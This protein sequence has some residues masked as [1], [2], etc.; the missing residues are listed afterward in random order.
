MAIKTYRVGKVLIEGS[1]IGNVDNAQLAIDFA[2]A[3]TQAIGTD[4]R[5]VTP[6][7]RGASL[8]LTCSYDPADVP[9]AAI[10]TEFISG[11]GLLSAIQMWEDVS[12][13]FSFSGCMVTTCNIAKTVG[14]VDKINI[15]LVAKGAVSYT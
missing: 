6:L 14:G 3:E 12:H 13:Y 4:W 2:N 10:R 1:Q 11:D 8:Q 15:T 9:Q 5:D 7:G